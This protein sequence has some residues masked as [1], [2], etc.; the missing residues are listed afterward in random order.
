MEALLSLEHRPEGMWF[1]CVVAAYCRSAPD[2]SGLTG[3]VAYRVTAT[4]LRDPPGGWA[5]LAG[6]GGGGGGGAEG[7]GERA[8]V[9]PLGGAW[10]RGTW[11][12]GVGSC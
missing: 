12:E 6:G 11:V 9:T 8:A 2:G 4:A 3:E 10:V 7:G 5:E 1:P